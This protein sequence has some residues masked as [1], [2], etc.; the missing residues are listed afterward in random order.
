MKEAWKEAWKENL[1]EGHRGTGTGTS[2]D[3]LIDIYSSSH[4]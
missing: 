2:S 1:D 3:S 4:A